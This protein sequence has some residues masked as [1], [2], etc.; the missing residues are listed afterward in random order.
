[1]TSIEFAEGRLSVHPTVDL[2][3]M[4]IVS[5]P[6]GQDA[7]IYKFDIEEV[8]DLIAVMQKIEREMGPRAEA[9]RAAEQMA[10]DLHDKGWTF[11]RFSDAMHAPGVLPYEVTDDIGEELSRL[12]KEGGQ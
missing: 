5:C 6:D 3:R 7:T 10:R 11:Q 1:M 12:D 8:R 4:C 2:S 9:R